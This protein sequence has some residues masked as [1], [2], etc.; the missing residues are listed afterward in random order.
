MENNTEKK[1][2]GAF[3]RF[4][5]NPKVRHGG[6]ASLITFAV[7]VAVIV[8]N[9]LVSQLGW[10]LDM[11]ENRV[12]TLSDQTKSVLRELE[13]DVTIYVLARRNNEPTQIME[14]LERYSQASSRVRIETVDADT[15]PGFVAQYDPDGEGLGN[16]SIIVATEDN[17]RPISILDL[18]SIDTRNP[19]SPQI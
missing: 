11:T 7:V 17:Y 19:Q 1:D 10:Q 9:L 4:L 15:N 16:G 6:Y 12:Y 18:Y 3:R 8:I 2:A 13:D 5:A 14:A